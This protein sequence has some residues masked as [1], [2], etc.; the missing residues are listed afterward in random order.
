MIREDV[1]YKT[2]KAKVIEAKI[3]YTKEELPYLYVGLY[4]VDNSGVEINLRR[5]NGDLENISWM[6]FFAQKDGTVKQSSVNSIKEAFPKWNY[7]LNWFQENISAIKDQVFF[8]TLDIYT[9]KNGNKHYQASYLSS[10]EPRV[11]KSVF[12]EWNDKLAMFN[13]DVSN[14]F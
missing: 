5:D 3:K 11:D 14:P 4:C 12:K 13:P 1:L 2:I 8:C 7:T 6:S 9:D 10:K